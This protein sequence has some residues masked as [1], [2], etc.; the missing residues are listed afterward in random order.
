M[1]GEWVY[2]N[3]VNGWDKADAAV[4]VRREEA[5]ELEALAVPLRET[6]KRV[7]GLFAQQAALTGA[8]QE[9]TRELNEL[10]KEGNAQVDLIKTAARVRYGKDSETLV[11][12]GVQPFRTRS[13]KAASRRP[14]PKTAERT[15]PAPDS[16][17]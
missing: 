14:V 8:K 3:T 4:T 1:A 2:M 9:V 11:E 10:I 17:Q 12:F 15:E 16:A 5:P 7:R 13:R 6:S